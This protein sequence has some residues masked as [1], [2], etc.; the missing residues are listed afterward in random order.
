VQK[1]EITR[2]RGVLELIQKRVRYGQEIKAH[3]Y[4]T[5]KAA[6]GTRWFERHKEAQAD[7]NNLK[8]KL[9]DALLNKTIKEFHISVHTD[10]VLDDSD[11]EAPY[12][13]RSHIIES[14]IPIADGKQYTNCKLHSNRMHFLSYQ[15]YK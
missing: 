1:F 4:P 11:S 8:R 6:T 7:I 12:A 9:S 3:G 13:Y 14:S 5:I 10:E 2:D 15:Q